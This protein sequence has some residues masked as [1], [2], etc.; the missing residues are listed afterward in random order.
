MI[1]EGAWEE[2][3][4]F[5]S[6]GI[7]KSAFCRVRGE[8]V[9]YRC[10]DET[11][12]LTMEYGLRNNQMHGCFRTWY[13]NGMLWEESY[14]LEGKE[15]GIAKQFNDQGELIGTYQMNY[16]TGVDL[17]Y[18]EKGL[19]AEERHYQNGERHG[20]ERWWN[21]N[22]Q[23]IYREQHF[24]QGIEHGIHREWNQK[25]RLRRGFPKY[26]V[27]GEKV[28]LV[29]YLKACSQDESLPKYLESDNDWR[30]LPP[31]EA[32]KQSRAFTE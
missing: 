31:R 9:G 18:Q 29:Q 25:G 32:G 1:P 5:W 21:G 12:Q 26:F 19:L 22:N 6:E 3:Q 8:N 20:Y 11:G 28:T 2:I 24:Q 17:W 4:E 16:G 13:S 23:T 7:P 30:R 15:H 14:Y 27:K 10:W